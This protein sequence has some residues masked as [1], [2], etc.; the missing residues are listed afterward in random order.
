MK[1]LSVR[2]PLKVG[3]TYSRLDGQE[4]TDGNRLGVRERIHADITEA[5]SR[6]RDAIGEDPAT[7][8]LFLIGAEEKP[9]EMSWFA[10]SFTAA[11]GPGPS[12]F[13]RADPTL[14]S[15]SA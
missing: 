15:H 3:I 9:T 5:L 1:L 6:V 11:D 13:L 10:L 8:Y 4:N 12:G 7:E 2:C 14:P